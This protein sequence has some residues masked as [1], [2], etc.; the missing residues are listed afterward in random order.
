[1]LRPGKEVECRSDTEYEGRRELIGI[2]VHPKLLLRRPQGAPH[3]V[4][5]RGGNLLDRLPRSMF[6]SR[7]KRRRESAYDLNAWI[8]SV[9]TLLQDVEHLRS[10]SEQKV[11]KP[12]RKSET[13]HPGHEIGAG[14]PL[15]REAEP[16]LQPS[17]GSPIRKGDPGVLE[18][19]PE[20]FVPPGQAENVDVAETTV[21]SGSLKSPL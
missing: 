16:A 5:P 3:Y 8:C 9:Q 14:H 15:R 13:E 2:A 11:A 21:S 6:V 4:R 1:M 19:P 20:T 7:L 17:H 18:C 10:G 12:R